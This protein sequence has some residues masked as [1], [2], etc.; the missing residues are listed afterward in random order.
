M[1]R[2]NSDTFLLTQGNV[3]TNVGGYALDNTILTTNNKLDSLSNT[4]FNKPLNK[5]TSSIDI[6][7]QTVNIDGG[8]ITINNILET[9][10]IS[11]FALE[12]T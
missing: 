10:L 6:S 11:G 8:E 2:L 12:T 4:V 5:E 1:S 3:N 7:G 9:P